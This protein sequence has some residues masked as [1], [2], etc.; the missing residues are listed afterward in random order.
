MKHLIVLVGLPGSGKSTYCK[1][2]P[3]YVRISQDDQGKKG[4]KKIFDDALVVGS[5]L[6]IDR[7]NFNKSQRNRYLVP[8]KEA[9]YKTS[10]VYL[11]TPLV[12]CVTRIKER[13]DHPNLNGTNPIMETVVLGFDAIMDPPDSDEADEVLII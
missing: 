5:D 1:N 2:Y 4:H 11:T 7:C 6:I 13:T 10:I 12:E 8:A 3:N 9:G